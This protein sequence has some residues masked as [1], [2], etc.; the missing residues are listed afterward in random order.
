MLF[1][2]YKIENISYTKYLISTHPAEKKKNPVTLSLID[3]MSYQSY[4]R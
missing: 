3:L 1:F 2:C 4:S